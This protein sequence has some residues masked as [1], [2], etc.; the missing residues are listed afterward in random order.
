MKSLE[1]TGTALCVLDQTRL[2]R[3]A[4]WIT[5]T[6]AEAVAQCIRGMQVRGAPAIAA[7]AAFGV[8]LTA[9]AAAADGV[10]WP[11]FVE[12]VQSSLRLLEAT[13]PTAVNLAWALRRMDAVLASAPPDPR[14][15]AEALSGEALRIA[16]LDVATNRAI[17]RH[18]ADLFRGPVRILTHCNTGSLATVEFGTALGVIR[19]LHARGQLLG[20]F[21]DETRPYLQGARLT[22]YELLA[23]GIPHTLIT[24][25]MAGYFMQQGQVDA[26]V[27]GADRI[28]KNGDTANKIGTYTLAVLCQYHGVPFYVA[29][30]C[31]TFDRA[32]ASGADIP[33]EQRHPREVLEVL[34]QRIAPEGTD[35]AHPA[36]DVTPHSLIGGIITEYGVIRDPSEENIAASWQHWHE[37]EVSR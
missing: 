12:R 20:V 29:A 4:V 26:V 2:P 21:V 14:A 30:P 6:S 34:G 28:A 17:G 16:H 8:V 36:F 13:R 35:A 32:T 37:A 15:A 11:D 27:V 7:A 10:P 24:D 33:I 3:D 9:Q 25:S 23:E 19:E 18:G 1:W 31:S 5:C 22:A